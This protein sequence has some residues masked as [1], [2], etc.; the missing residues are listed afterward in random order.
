MLAAEIIGGK[1]KYYLALFIVIFF[2]TSISSSNI[3][4]INPL[5][6]GN[7]LFS[8]FNLNGTVFAVGEYGTIMKSTDAG[9]NWDFENKVCGIESH[10]KDID[11]LD[12][13]FGLIVGEEGVVL[14][15]DNGGNSWNCLDSGIT[16]DI[17]CIEIIN[18]SLIYVGTSQGLYKSIDLGNEW[19]HCYF[20]GN[21]RSIDFKKKQLEYK[22]KTNSKK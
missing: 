15:T 9:E 12:S 1:V 14:K 10:L 8:T 4:W 19:T 13:D 6:Q 7:S 2:V 5:P 16:A 3:S 11:F 20:T 21:I 18:Q 17:N 22:I